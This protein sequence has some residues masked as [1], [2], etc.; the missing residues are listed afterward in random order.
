MAKHLYVVISALSNTAIWR[1]RQKLHL[2]GI[3]AMHELLT[4]F[5]AQLLLKAQTRLS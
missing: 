1:P 5:L 3:C 4:D 2:H